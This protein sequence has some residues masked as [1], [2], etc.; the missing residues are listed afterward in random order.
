MATLDD[1]PDEVL[2]QIL[3]E[4]PL[5]DAIDLMEGDSV[6][7]GLDDW[8]Y[9]MSLKYPE[10]HWERPLSFDD[11]IL[12]N[13]ALTTPSPSDF[14]MLLDHGLVSAASSIVDRAGTEW[15]NVLMTAAGF[16]AAGLVDTALERMDH[17]PSYQTIRLA[18]ADAASNGHLD[19]VKMLLDLPD[20]LAADD[21]YG[22]FL[23]AAK[24][25]NRDVAEYL[26]DQ[27]D[28][29]AGA[30]GNRAFISTVANGHLGMARFLAALP[31]VDPAANDSDALVIAS[32]QGNMPMVRFLTS[33]DGVDAAAQDNQAIID[34]SSAGHLD[35][36]EFL[37]GLPGV[38]A[39][40]QEN[41]AVI[42]AGRNGYP[43]VVDFLLS[44]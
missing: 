21:M 31:R 19:V 33:L 6:F 18:I 44:N 34:A 26:L 42:E 16:G 39:S 43:D 41:E 1:L 28:I 29:D 22:T 23:L 8:R 14:V 20:R 13:D 4:L 24:N 11:V 9:I 12:I 3:A 27:Y 2:Y 32:M 25:G 40:A 35:V 36:V 17:L 30:N 7:H 15:S 5:R 38:D 10:I 37:A